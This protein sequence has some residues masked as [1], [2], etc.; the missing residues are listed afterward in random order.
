MWK[1]SIKELKLEFKADRFVRRSFLANQFRLLLHT[2]ADCLF[3][4]LRL[5][6]P[7]TELDTAQVNTLR[8]KH[9]KIGA[10]IRGNQPSHFGES[11][12]RVSLP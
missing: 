9:L 6:L 10:S 12:L 7:D 3:W 8:L 11:G 1:I 4:L 5:H 2:A